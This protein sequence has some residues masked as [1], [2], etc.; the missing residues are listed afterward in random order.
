MSKPC[1]RVGL[2]ASRT[3]L[4]QVFTPNTVFLHIIKKLCDHIQL[5]ISWKNLLLFFLFSILIHLD[6][7]L[8]IVFNNQRQLFFCKNIFPQI[9]GHQAIGIRWIT[10][11]I[12]ISLIERQKPT[13]FTREASAEFNAGVIHG[14][15]HHAAFELEQHLS[16]IAIILVLLDSIIHILL[17]K[18]VFE[19]KGDDRQSIDK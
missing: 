2:A 12:I 14:Q 11:S 6:N 13:V 18:L 7:N 17:C 3:V 10:R 8:S 9:V 15:M 19:F 5:M 1:D 4:D 16:R